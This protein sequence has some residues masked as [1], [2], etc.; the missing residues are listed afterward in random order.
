MIN[1]PVDEF[2]GSNYMISNMI[3]LRLAAGKITD[4]KINV[5]AL[6]PGSYVL[7]IMDNT[8]NIKTCRFIKE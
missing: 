1:L 7:T 3:G 6:F 4:G 8:G 5:S 2:T